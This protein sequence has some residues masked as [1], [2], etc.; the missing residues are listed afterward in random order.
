MPA[1]HTR[2]TPRRSPPLQGRLWLV[3]LS[4][5]LVAT[6]VTSVLLT[7]GSPPTRPPK[8]TTVAARHHGGSSNHSDP[9]G[10]SIVS[11]TPADGAQ[12]VASNET[13]SV[14]FSSPIDA[15]SPHPTLT[16]D[17]GGTWVRTSPTVLQY[18]LSGPFV[19]SEPE[20][21]TIPGGAGGIRGTHG[22][23]LASTTTVQFSIAVGD[24]T[25][26]QQLL[27]EL[28][29]LPLSF[30]PTGTTAPADAALPQPGS[31]AWRWSTLPASLTSQWTAGQAD[32]ITKAAVMAFENVNNLT[33]DGEAGPEVW[34]TLLTDVAAGKTNPNPYTY[35]FVTKVLPEN[36][37]AYVN[38]VAQFVGIP[39]NTGAPGADTQ[40]GTFAVFE[41]VKASDMKGTNPNGTKY[42]DPDVPW[43]SYF[44][45]GDAL[46]GFVRAQYGFPQSNG[47]V[48]MSVADA[49]ALWPYT[50]I[51]TLVTVVGPS[52]GPGPATTTTTTTAPPTTTTAPPATTTTAPPTT[53]TTTTAP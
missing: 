15:G 7:G 10:L 49:G 46:H 21:L 53:T 8:A 36:L 23:E 48:E 1:A 2:R 52:S 25:R 30:T 28:D 19:P 42:N 45:G 4:A 50:P 17:V 20:T 39:V 51:G 44:N 41:H 47:C 5:A 32:E 34:S 40:D 9:A 12:G 26:L 38:G 37:T 24:E 27:A 33:V 31:F 22:A 6:V 13:V 11:T 16:P 29:Y 14:T 35:V 3:V 18:D 43:A